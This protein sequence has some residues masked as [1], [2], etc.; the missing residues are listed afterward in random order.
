MYI[1]KRSI[2]IR[3]KN[4]LTFVSSG[5]IHTC[6][7]LNFNNRSLFLFFFFIYFPSFQ[8]VETSTNIFNFFVPFSAFVYVP[9]NLGI[10]SIFRQIIACFDR[11]LALLM[12][13]CSNNSYIN[14]EAVTIKF[15]VYM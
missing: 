5:I 9:L 2:A 11:S 15:S 12:A 8:I 4:H 10:F 3:K 13:N 14:A 6:S 7:N 1:Y